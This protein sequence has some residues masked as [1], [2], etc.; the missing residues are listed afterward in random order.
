MSSPHL[1]T[2]GRR[3]LVGLG[4]AALGAGVF[5]APAAAQ[6]PEVEATFVEDYS[7]VTVGEDLKLAV[8]QIVFSEAFPAGHELT[9]TITF[10]APEGTFTLDNDDDADCA[11]LSDTVVECQADAA[12][13]VAFDYLYAPVLEAE[14]RDYDYTVEFKVDGATVATVDDVIEVSAH[15]VEPFLYGQ[16]QI[17]I[18]PGGSHETGPDF[19]Q[20][21][22]LPGDTVAL[23]YAVAEPSYI[24]TG[25][26]EATAPYEN[27]VDGYWGDDGGVTCIVT[28]Y[29]DIPGAVFAPDSPF[30]FSVGENVPGPLEICGCT[31]EV[32]ALDAATLESEYGDVDT[33][34]G[35]QLGFELVSE[36]GDPEHFDSTGYIDI[37]TGE[38]PFNLSVAAVNAKG[39]KDAQVTLTVPVKNLGPADAINVF[40]GPGSYGLIGALP[41]GLELVK[42]DGDG[43]EIS[44]FEPD[45][46]MIE[47]SFPQVDPAKTDFV[48][49]FSSLGEGESFDFKFTVKITDATANAKGTLEVAAIDNDGYPGI[50][51]A[52]TKNNKADITVNGSGSG[53]GST[54]PKLPKTGVSLGMIIGAAALVL[55][56]GVVMFA[57][58][59]RRRKAGAEV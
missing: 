6:T 30:T 49:I 50:A 32:R 25:T 52:D 23:A 56:A 51:D 33:E 35:D 5:A 31:F 43:D 21:E 29:E 40:D 45:D 7:P 42:I 9:A 41:K 13:S 14:P 18:D 2:T 22:A 46:P 28:D 8:A 47:Q 48:C 38:N 16:D 19:M 54:T 10:D 34:N 11:A 36:G 59:S 57:L 24:L 44:C 39:A 37:R 17:D 55:V 15:S 27:C 58:T 1:R 20:T 53:N 4:A 3:A 12:E 26:A